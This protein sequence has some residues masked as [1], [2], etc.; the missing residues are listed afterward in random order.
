MAIWAYTHI[1]NNYNKP[2]SPLNDNF[3]FR[4]VLWNQDIFPFAILTALQDCWTMQNS[5]H[6]CISSSSNSWRFE[7]FCPCLYLIITH[8]LKNSNLVYM[9]MQMSNNWLWH[10][11]HN[12]GKIEYTS[13]VILKTTEDARGALIYWL[14][15]SICPCCI[16]FFDRWH[17]HNYN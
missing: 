3:S 4:G 11:N 16:T 17:V 13:R 5:S 15:P 7:S 10:S 1:C 8:D 14:F 9:Y 12:F 6:W 2:N